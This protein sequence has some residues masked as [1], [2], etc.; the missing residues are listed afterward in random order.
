M[1]DDQDPFGPLPP[2][3]VP[4]K[5]RGPFDS[6]LLNR[7]SWQWTVGPPQQGWLTVMGSRQTGKARS[8]DEAVAKA[9]VVAKEIAAD[10]N[11]PDRGLYVLEGEES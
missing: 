8:L 9:T 6:R 3:T 10:L 1:S 4:W 11:D 2:W 5:V 7:R